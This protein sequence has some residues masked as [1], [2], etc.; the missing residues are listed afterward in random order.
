ME[1][2]SLIDHRSPK[3]VSQL[4]AIIWKIPQSHQVNDMADLMNFNMLKGHPKLTSNNKTTIDFIAC[5]TEGFICQNLYGPEGQSRVG[6]L[7]CSCSAWES[8]VTRRQSGGE[9]YN[10]GT[11]FIITNNKSKLVNTSLSVDLS[12]VSYIS[13]WTRNCV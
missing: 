11:C 4:T 6:V 9:S 12:L 7:T 10:P 1:M 2:I 13:L 8:G 5:P 3:Q